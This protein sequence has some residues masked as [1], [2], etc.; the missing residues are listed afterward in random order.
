MIAHLRYAWLGLVFVLMSFSVLAQFKPEE[1]MKPYAYTNELGEVLTC[2]IRIPQFLEPGKK[3]PLILFLHG[4]GECG[5]ENEKQTRVGLPSLLRQ[6]VL[7]PEP[8]IVVAPQCQ[9]GNW[10]VQKLAMQPD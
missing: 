1:M 9:A 3:Y 7:Q 4:S 10:W 2:Q 8:V 6:L 5:K